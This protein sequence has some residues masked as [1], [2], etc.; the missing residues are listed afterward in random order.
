MIIQHS[1]LTNI[2]K[3][4]GFP[5]GS[6]VNNLPANAGD[7]RDVGSIPGLGR[8]LGVRNDNPLQCSCLENSMGSQRVRYDLV[9]KTHTH[10]QL[11]KT[12]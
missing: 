1:N 10:M 6:V 9:T 8:S 12:V 7:T 3:I 2:I 11:D 4:A 5:G